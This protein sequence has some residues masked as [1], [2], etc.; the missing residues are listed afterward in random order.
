MTDQ[1]S[2]R[3]VLGKLPKNDSW[4]KQ[5][6]NGRRLLTA[7][8][9][10]YLASTGGVGGQRREPRRRRRRRS[11]QLDRRSVEKAATKERPFGEP[12][13][14]DSTRRDEVCRCDRR[15]SLRATKQ[16]KKSR[17]RKCQS[18]TAQ[19]R[20][21]RGGA[22]ERVAAQ[23]RR[24]ARA[25]SRCVAPACDDDDRDERFDDD[26]ATRQRTSSA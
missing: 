13:S 11:N 1:R 20:N 9:Q 21:R 26:G 22:A 17:S 16:T 5:V 23:R 10:E 3:Q 4:S 12:P 24:P 7:K 18:R 15:Q 2:M 19:G 14:A 8:P 6:L 25:A